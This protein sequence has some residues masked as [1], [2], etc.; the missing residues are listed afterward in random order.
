MQ[1]I[2]ATDGSSYH[3]DNIPVGGAGIVVYLNNEIHKYHT[4]IPNSEITIEISN[5]SNPNK[6]IIY[7]IDNPSS[8][9][10]KII[11]QIEMNII[12]NNY[13]KPT[14][15]RA[16]LFAILTACYLCLTEYKQYKDIIIYTDSQ[17]V[18]SRIGTDKLKKTNEEIKTFI[19]SDIILSIK[20]IMKQIITDRNIYIKWIR[21]HRSKKSINSLN[22]TDKFEAQLNNLADKCANYK[23]LI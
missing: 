21:A 9:N 5:N 18:L 22:T 23:L 4:K 16:E 10:I 3:I 20:S 7:N 1:L 19:N 15:N 12:L 13:Q 2:L 6:H 11:N 8:N 17:Y 14:N